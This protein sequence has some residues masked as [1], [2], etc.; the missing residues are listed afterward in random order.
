MS[1]ISPFGATPLGGE[2]VYRLAARLGDDAAAIQVAHVP[3]ISVASAAG[4]AGDSA[5]LAG[6]VLPPPVGTWLMA[7]GPLDSQPEILGAHF[8]GM[9]QAPGPIGQP[10]L[11]GQPLWGAL[12]AASPIGQPAIVAVALM[13]IIDTPG[14]LG[15]P[16]ILGVSLMARLLA[17][18][19]LGRPTLMG[20][21]A[22]YGLLT[23]HGPLGQPRLLGY[24]DYTQAIQHEAVYYA[25]EVSGDPVLRIPISSWQGTLRSNQQ[26]YLQA[27]VPAAAA[28]VE[29][30]NLR[31]AAS[32]TFTVLRTV[33]LPGGGRYDYVMMAAPLQQVRVDYGSQRY[34]AMLIGYIPPVSAPTPI[35]R[36]LTQVQ[37]ISTNNATMRAR[38]AINWLLQPGDIAQAAGLS[39]TVKW[40]SY[41]M[42]EYGSYMDVGS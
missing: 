26:S 4:L 31:Q 23:S 6:H 5:A 29:E 42:G 17:P 21:V 28:Y 14:P 7:K 12:A 38:G 19:P 20:Q 8:I 3:S 10:R 25:L 24:L 37:S 2:S 36:P 30:L 9:M 18:G 41:Y 13:G 39:F 32:A 27:V 11:V 33:P 16:N 34:T 1:G 22:A 35:T 40:I 15:R